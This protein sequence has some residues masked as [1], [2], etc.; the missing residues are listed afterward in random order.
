[1]LSEKLTKLQEVETLVANATH[2]QQQLAEYNQSQ[3]DHIVSKMAEISV[4][5]AE[6]LARL[7]AGETKMG[8]VESKTA[9]NLFAAQDIYESI[10]HEKT[11]G[12]LRYDTDSNCYEVA[13]PV[14]TIAAIIPTTNPTST[15]IYKILIAIK[16]RNSIVL[17]PHPRSAN[18]V[19][20]TTEI[21]REAAV[22]AGLPA[23]AIGCLNHPTLEATQRLMK[24]PGV[25]LILA[26]GGPGLVKAAYSS[27]KPA[28]G[29]GAG[30]P[31]A[32]I[33]KS[34]DISHAV[35]CI[36]TS[37][38]FDYG[39]ICSSEQ[40]VIVESSIKDQVVS[41]FKKHKAYFLNK[42]ETKKLS[43]V[44]V[45]NKMMNP[46]IVGQPAF[47]IAQKANI[48]VP[49]DTSVLLAPLDGCGEK[50]PLSYETLA[51]ILAFYEVKSVKE[52]LDLG[53]ALLNLGGRGHT[54]GVHS[55]NS[56]VVMKCA[57]RQPVSRIVV[58]GPTSQG[59]VG[60][61]TN[62]LPSMTL[63]CGSFGNNIISDNI[64]AK[65]LL[66]IKRVTT[67]REDFPLWDDQTIVDA[68][69]RHLDLQEEVQ[70]SKNNIFCYEQKILAEKSAL[71]LVPQKFVSSQ[72]LKK[73]GWPYDA[74]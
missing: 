49:M 20:K 16:A 40:S 70:L 31:P 30:N 23:G 10:R 74:I 22:E 58:N 39:T 64:S 54:F 12:I 66:N 14:G 36:V 6:M 73:R 57:L 29:V 50:Y 25:S 51:P 43:Q 63:G 52:A 53:E 28:Y 65:H 27:G 2:A 4:R 15:A 42:E 37:Q 26:T 62:L 59:G 60:F 5:S 17:A 48:N 34:A 56:E 67:L 69:N 71:D 11:T 44:A 8:R 45:R 18:C 61:A 47:V 13:D 68:Q 38:L 3:V 1:M 35:N 19:Y 41:E 32:F 9:K 7:A 46:D 33:E 21:L 72:G 24:H 55:T